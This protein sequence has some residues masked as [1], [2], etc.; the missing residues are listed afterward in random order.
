LH[1]LTQLDALTP[2]F[3]DYPWGEN[4]Y[5]LLGM[6]HL[7]LRQ[8]EPAATCFTMAAHAERK[9]HGESFVNPFNYLY[10]AIALDEQGHYASGLQ[11][12]DSMQR[13][14]PK[15]S[16]LYYFKALACA[17]RQ[18]LAAA[19]RFFQRSDSLYRSGYHSWNSYYNSPYPV[20]SFTIAA[21]R[22]ELRRR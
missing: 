20:D 4:I 12:L 21:S 19:E 17:K 14:Q 15:S 1:D 18:H 9:D 10:K 13:L 7:Q 8:W 3:V 5:F 6:D 16:E 11:N 2:G 22:A